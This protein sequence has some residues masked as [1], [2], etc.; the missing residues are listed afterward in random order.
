MINNILLQLEDVSRIY[1]KG[2]H[3]LFALD[4]LTTEIRKSEILSIVGRSGSGKSTLLNLIGGLDKP[5]TGKLIYMGKDLAK[6]S[7]KELSLYRK[8]RVGMIFQSFN[9]IP[10]YNALENVSLALT[11]GGVARSERRAIATELLSQ[12]GLKD[13]ILH[14]PSELSGGEAQRVAIARALANKPEIILADEPSGNLDSTSSDEIIHILKELNKYQGITILMVTHDQQMAESISHRF[15]RL[16][17]GKIVEDYGYWDPSEII[18][19]L[20]EIE[21]V[22]NMSVDD[23]ALYT[24]IKNMVTIWNKNDQCSINF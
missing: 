9:L 13:R 2:E 18:L 19:A 17:D 11:F 23:K 6:Y 14:K 12:V 16:V 1:H 10:S 7:Q 5:T 15:I 8:F 3:T 4:S 24:T 20:Q 21:A 22:N